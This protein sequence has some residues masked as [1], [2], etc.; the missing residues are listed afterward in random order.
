ML[1]F[2]TRW[3]HQKIWFFN[4][5]SSYR[6]GIFAWN[7]SICL[8]TKV[9][10]IWFFSTST[11]PRN[12]AE[13]ITLKN[14]NYHHPQILQ[15]SYDIKTLMSFLNVSQSWVYCHIRKLIAVILSIC[16]KL[17]QFMKILCLIYLSVTPLILLFE[18]LH[19]VYR[20]WNLQEL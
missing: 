7:G 6:Y 14:K 13:S 11:K 12:S 3:K 9:F 16:I 2:Y 18:F 10:L 4:V 15:R 1:L 8:L 20:L 5:F 17:T 19:S